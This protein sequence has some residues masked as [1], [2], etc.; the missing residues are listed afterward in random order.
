MLLIVVNSDRSGRKTERAQKQKHVYNSLG[1]ATRWS[2]NQESGYQSRAFYFHGVLLLYSVKI[3]VVKSVT[4][5]QY[6][7]CDIISDK[8]NYGGQY[9]IT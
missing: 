1:I 9:I 8:F 4:R 5:L 6:Q 3:H 2:V 7:V